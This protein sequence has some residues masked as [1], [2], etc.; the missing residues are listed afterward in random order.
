MGSV[1][2]C[3]SL[4]SRESK[5]SKE[6]EEFGSI[7]KS[8]SLKSEATATATGLGIDKVESL[9][10]LDSLPTT[11]DPEL[12]QGVHLSVCLSG[13]GKLSRRTAVY[14]TFLSHDWGTP[15][16]LKFIALVV[17]FNSRAAAVASAV[18]SLTVG[19]L[20]ATGLLPD[21]LWTACNKPRLIRKIR[22]F[23]LRPQIVFL[24]KLCIDQHDERLKEKGILGLAGF[25]DNTKKLTVL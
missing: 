17:I 20:R 11:L 10:S 8:D 13:W 14:D 22:D 23:V 12:L 24:D 3:D 19:V 21:E 25:L 2:R 7:A 6:S 5:E 18:V 9:C 4:N 1:D 15:R 16:W